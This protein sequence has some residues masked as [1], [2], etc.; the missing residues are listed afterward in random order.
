[1]AGDTIAFIERVIGA[2]VYLMGCSDGAVVALHVARRR[3]GLVR[4]LVFAAGVFHHDGWEEGVLDGEPPDWLRES[5]GELSPDGIG[6][7]DTVAAKLAAMHASEPAVP[8]TSHGLLAE[9]PDLCN[10]L[11]TG[12]LTSDPVQTYA[13][14]RRARS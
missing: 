14:I 7:Y 3:P 4:R 8:G 12:F 1:M 10:T 11:M 5:Y 2:P 9:K 6:H 13:P